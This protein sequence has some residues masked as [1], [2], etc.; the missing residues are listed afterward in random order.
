M[1]SSSERWTDGLQFSS[2]FWPPPQDAQQ[3]KRLKK[4]LMQNNVLLRA[5]QH[6]SRGDGLVN[7]EMDAAGYY[8]GCW[9]II[10]EIWNQWGLLLLGKYGKVQTKA[11]VEYFGQFTSEQFREDIAELIRNRY[12]SKEKR[13]FDD[14]LAMFV[15][16]HPEH[17][18]AV[19]LPIISCII[20]GTLVYDSSAPPF[21][22]FISVVCPSSEN[23]YSEQWALACGEILRILTHYNRPIYNLEQQNSE[24]ERSNSGSQAT[25]SDSRDGESAHV[26]LMLHD[27]KPLRPLSPWITDI[28]LAAPLGIR[29]DY[30]RW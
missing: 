16:H 10:D 17:G 27:R 6:A 1:A 28:L 19:L 21:A 26:P 8:P 13:L 2:L 25:T 11:Y 15:L 24:T 20:D 5:Y 22:S 29:S 9:D 7:K 30:F 4:W 18:H 3:R 14:V 23:E 12:P